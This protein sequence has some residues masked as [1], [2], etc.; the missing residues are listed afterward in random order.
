[1]EKVPAQPLYDAEAWERLQKNSAFV[2][3][4]AYS[5]RPE[6]WAIRFPALVLP[7]ET[8]NNAETGDDPL[9]PQI[10]IH[11]TD[12]WSGILENGH[13]TEAS[14][15]ETRQKLRQ[16]MQAMVGSDSPKNPAFIDGGPWSI[17]PAKKLSFKGGHGYRFI[18]QWSYEI[19]L[20]SRGRLHYLFLGLSEDSSCQIIATFP[21]NHPDLPG[22]YDQEA[23]HLGYSSSRSRYE[24]LTQKFDDYE[25]KAKQWVAD[26]IS[27]FTPSVEKLDRLI[28]SLSAETWR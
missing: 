22:Y 2:L 23:T 13:S 5:V 14:R 18:A 25:S 19:S 17:L 8:F 1:M 12:G 10:L 9:A 26:H 6:H 3:K 21:L 20:L 15:K 7:G 24:E 11:Q 28:E 4:P 16:E 27:E